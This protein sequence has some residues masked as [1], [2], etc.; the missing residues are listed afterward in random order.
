MGLLL[1]THD[2]GVVAGSVDEVLVMQARPRGRARTGRHEVL[3]APAAA[4]HPGAAGRR[5]AGGRGR[6]A[7][8]GAAPGR[9]RCWTVTRPARGSSAARRGGTR[10]ARSTAC[11]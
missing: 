4:V 1:V 8:R 6:G 10:R 7:A 3:G 11:R 9:G 2:L 5:P